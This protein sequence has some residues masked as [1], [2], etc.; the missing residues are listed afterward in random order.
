M[1]QALLIHWSRLASR[2]PLSLLACALIASALFAFLAQKNLSPSKGIGAMLSGS[3]PKFKSYMEILYKFPNE[4]NIAVLVEGERPE[5]IRYVRS[6]NDTLSKMDDLVMHFNYIRTEEQVAVSG[7][8]IFNDDELG[9]YERLIFSE[10]LSS[11]IEDYTASVV[12]PLKGSHSSNELDRLSDN[13]SKISTSLSGVLRFGDIYKDNTI[14]AIS[15]ADNL[16]ETFLLGDPYYISPDGGSLIAFI[17]PAF[18]L[19]YDNKGNEIDQFE[20]MDRVGKITDIVEDVAENYSIKA[21]TAGALAIGADEQKALANEGSLMS[22]SSLAAVVLIFLVFF[23]SF[24]MVLSPV[25]S[26][27]TVIIGMLWTVGLVSVLIDDLIIFSLAVLIAVFGLGI[28]FCIHLYSEYASNIRITG[29]TRI[30]F[31]KA[32][33]GAFCKAGPG[34]MM[35]AVTTSIAFFS[36]S[37]S[38]AEMMS[39]MG[40]VGGL[41]IVLELIAAFTILPGCLRIIAHF[42]RVGTVSKEE[43]VSSTYFHITSVSVWVRDNSRVASSAIA[44]FTLGMIW[45][46][47]MMEYDYNL[48]NLEPKGMQSVE[49]QAK[50]VDSFG[51]MSDYAMILI[52]T[53]DDGSTDIDRLIKTNNELSKLE[54]VGR[55]ESVASFIPKSSLRTRME[56]NKNK[57]N[58]YKYKYVDESGDALLYALDNLQAA[59]LEIDSSLV[60]DAHSDLSL[61]IER[62]A[63]PDGAI[64]RVIAL[65]DREGFDPDSF[66]E[67]LNSL[68]LGTQ[69]R[70][71][72]LVLSD[73]A[74]ESSRIN[75]ISMIPLSLRK[76]YAVQDDPSKDGYTLVVRVFPRQDFYKDVMYYERFVDEVESVSESATGL[77]IVSFYM[78]DSFASYGKVS[79]LIS[80]LIIFI[81]LAIDFRSLRTASVALS[82][83]VFGTIWMVGL[84]YLVGMKFNMSNMMVIPLIIGI[85]IDDGIHILHRYN[86]DRSLRVTY[87]TTG[88]A[89]LVTTL[90]TAIGFGSLCISSFPSI[91]DLGLTLA[92]GAVSCYL[93]TILL[94]PILL[95]KN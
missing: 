26:M 28:D 18:N 46:A 58:R 82:V 11:A 37:L 47:S 25:I 50:I 91:Y 42:S 20:V 43:V 71:R 65:Y 38:S 5:M 70:L 52:P 77:P 10:S 29:P 16:S 54:T 45:M 95:K 21:G 53:K 22:V 41:G 48:M 86:I 59:L 7:L 1:R 88:K 17:E 66:Y 57:L 44:I 63:G 27:V 90:T 2:Y 83:L 49:N 81:I 32:V 3:D 72:A 69:E 31:E 89:V 62:V 15:V 34:I 8:G 13:V 74:I 64:E 19:G 87:G 61:R 85:G 33:E 84:M 23:L 30:G 73:T 80:M 75:S 78:M 12:A 9:Q 24:R 35:G 56:R 55:V 93:A 67:S 40:I 4:S 94:V 92:L 79:M 68:Y 39:Q 51:I 76:S 6:L 14:E 36:L 60:N